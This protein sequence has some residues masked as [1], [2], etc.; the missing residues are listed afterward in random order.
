MKLL[1]PLIFLVPFMIDSKHSVD[2]VSINP[3]GQIDSNK[4]KNIAIF[5]YISSYND[6]LESENNLKSF[7]LS[8]NEI[9]LIDTLFT[10]YLNEYNKKQERVYVDF[11]KVNPKSLVPEDNFVIKEFPYYK[12]QYIP[13]L[14]SKGEK[15]VWI[16]CFCASHENVNW[17]KEFVIV[18]DGGT[19]YFHLKINL[20]TRQLYDL[21]VNGDA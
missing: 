13:Y 19:C 10:A 6:L 4:I 8:T 21:I 17:R 16:N 9:E 12:R 11:I 1:A 18:K 2:N 5:D 14:N 3:W 20:T 7:K 15:V